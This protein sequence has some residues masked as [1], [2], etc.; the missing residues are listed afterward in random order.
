[1]DEPRAHSARGGP[2]ANLTDIIER[3]L[4]EERIRHLSYYDALTDLPNR[5]L[6]TK[7]VDQALRDNWRPA[8]V[9]KA[10]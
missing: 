3:N 2:V 8:Q 1:M 10:A 7:L 5:S 9:D 6:L 4:A